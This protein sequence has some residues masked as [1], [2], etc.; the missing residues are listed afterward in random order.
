M[1]QIRDQKELDDNLANLLG[2]S[3]KQTQQNNISNLSPFMQIVSTTISSPTI[4]MA[5][6]PWKFERTI[7]AAFSNSEL[8]TKFNGDLDT[9]FLSL[10]PSV[11]H[12]GSEFRPVSILLDLLHDHPKWEKFE[13]IISH[14]V[15]YPALPID[16]QQQL[17]DLTF[18]LQCGYHKSA[19]TG[20]SLLVVEKAYNLEVAKGW[21]LPILPSVIPIIKNSCITPLGTSRQWTINSDK[22]RVQKYRVIHDCSFPS[23]SGTS[24]NKQINKDLLEPCIYGNALRCIL[25]SVYS[26]GFRHP[27]LR[28]LIQPFVAFM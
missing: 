2:K 21:Q 23:D 24:I 19:L 20:D 25:H 15:I 22:E 4:N 9:L 12:Y 7:E 5:P 13:S 6:I 11:T 8:I 26:M 10:P 14:G 3:L 28:I 18:M 17:S 1:Q 27:Q 16:E